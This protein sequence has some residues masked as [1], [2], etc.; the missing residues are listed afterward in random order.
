MMSMYVTKRDG[1][2][3]TF[4]RSKIARAILGAVRDVDGSENEGRELADQIA[5]KIENQ[6]S[7]TDETF[8]IEEIQD[9]VETE[10]MASNRKDVARAYITY[11]NE[12]TRAR[13]RD[14]ELMRQIGEKL[15]ATNVVN[16][17]ANVDERSFGGRMGE[18]RSIVV[19]RYALDHLVSEK[20]RKH[21]DNN[22]IYL[23]DLDSY[24]VGEHNCL[25]LPIDDLLANGFVTR[26]TDVRP[27]GSVK[28][29]MQL[30]AVLFQLQSLCQFGGVAASHL[31]W[32]MVPYVRKSFSKHYRDGMRFIANDPD[33]ER[34]G[35]KSIV[36]STYRS[37]K[38]VYEYALAMTKEEVKQATEAMFHNLNLGRHDGNV[39]NIAA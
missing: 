5:M 15:N 18:A 32:S 17:N 26:Q 38:Q 16:Q 20:T 28:S 39:M 35:E 21:H 7:L 8:G 3:V 4:D 37:N 25:T 23:H 36:D 33:Y 1:R 2:T 6:A 13:E 30:V 19:K 10:L 9:M 12:R 22:E 27:A 34:D 24:A 11:R 14:S 29:A 31:D